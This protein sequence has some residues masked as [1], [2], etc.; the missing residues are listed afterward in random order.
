[1]RVSNGHLFVPIGDDGL[2]IYRAE[3]NGDL[4][5]RK[6]I[7]AIDLY[8]VDLDIFITDVA[9]GGH[10]GQYLYVLD[11]TRGITLFNIAD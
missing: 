7:D 5:F 9:I 11:K 1:M 3:P 2:D 10:T 4:T 8:G 6:N